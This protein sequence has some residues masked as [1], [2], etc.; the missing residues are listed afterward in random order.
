MQSNKRKAQHAA[1]FGASPGFWNAIMDA[2]C[3]V[4]AHNKFT[5]TARCNTRTLAVIPVRIA[6]NV[7]FEILHGAKHFPIAVTIEK[8]CLRET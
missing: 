4:S 7:S 3:E 5:V 2:A 6:S 1:L 8:L